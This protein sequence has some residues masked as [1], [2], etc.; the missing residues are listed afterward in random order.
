MQYRRLGT[1]NLKVSALCLGTMMFADQTDFAEARN[2][3][4]SASEHGVNFID[5]ADVYSKGL[6]EEMVG[7]L[8]NEK[9]NDW[10][11]A[12]KLGNSMSKAPNRSH[13]S[14]HWMMR[15]VE[16]SLN[17]LST[18]HIDILYMH[19]DFHEENLDEAVRTMGDLI[20]SGKIRAFGVSNF[21]GWRIAEIVRLCEKANVP[22]PVVCQ[23]Y[24]NL[25]NRGPE[26]EILP[27]CAHYGLGVVPYSPIARG[28]LTG[29]Y[30]P[31]QA[32]AQDSR[33]GRGDKRILETEFREESLVIARKL[34]EHCDE[35]GIKLGQFATAWVLANPHISAVIAGPRTLLQM[36]DY[37]PAVAIEITAEEES[38]VD[39]LVT[40]GHASTPGYND[41][42]YPFFGRPRPA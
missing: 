2:I 17:R 32:P 15:E 28:V 37:Y 30:L 12:T 7:K 33:A 9:R 23:P 10:V 20:Q 38:M 35:K 42:T 14:R 8:I 18:D 22:Q 21:R 31:G 26:V 11:L 39:D 3:V 19:R 25:L 4:A 40:P 29:K 24:Y 36:E 1:S 27:A 16:N 6:C 5:T 13:Y 41:P 34:Q